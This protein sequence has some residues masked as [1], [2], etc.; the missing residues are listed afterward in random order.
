MHAS[1]F[2]S[3]YLLCAAITAAQAADQPLPP[4]PSSPPP[5]P[6]PYRPAGTPVT[7]PAPPPAPA[8][9]VEQLLARHKELLPTLIPLLK[10]PDAEIRQMAAVTLTQL[11]RHAV[12]AL[13]SA[14]TEK[15]RDLRANAAHVLGQLGRTSQEALPALLKALKDED[16]EVRRRSAYAIQCVV[17][18]T[19]ANPVQPP[20]PYV[21]VQAAC[22]RPGLLY[23][24]GAQPRP[25]VVPTAY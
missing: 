16:A 12:P 19:G 15:D 14:L 7:Q 1:A 8:D 10:D 22:C 5:A 2:V 17:A 20:S 3:V 4:V 21:P 25:Q 6:A 23:P 18:D 9:G 13:T 24:V 11:G